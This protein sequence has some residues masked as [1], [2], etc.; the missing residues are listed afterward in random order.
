MVDTSSLGDRIKAYESA[1]ETNLMRR[2][3]IIVRCDGK[4]FST[5]THGLKK[6]FD[7]WLSCIMSETMFCVAKEIDGCAYGYTQSDEMTFVIRNDKTLNTEP[8]FGNR[9][10]KICSVVSSLVTGHF[11]SI[12]ASTVWPRPVFFDARVF[13]VPNLVEAANTLI[14]RQN[15]CIKNS[16]SCACYYEVARKVGKKTARGMMHGLNQNQQQELLFRETGIN[17]STYPARF[18]NGIGCYKIQGQDRLGW[19]LESNLPRWTAEGEFQ[20]LLDKFNMGY[21]NN[22]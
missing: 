3:P 14:W 17:W 8:W 11:N 15:D 7:E 21:E 6:P 2:V 4:A 1:C 10:Q 12:K 19:H 13:I 20:F 18:K 9:L 16:I 5:L 22:E